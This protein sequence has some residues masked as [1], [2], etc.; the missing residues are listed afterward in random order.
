MSELRADPPD[1]R[2]E[3]AAS[4][5]LRYRL[6]T[7]ACRLMRHPVLPWIEHRPAQRRTTRCLCGYVDVG[8]LGWVDETW[9]PK[10]DWVVD[11]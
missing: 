1:G 7:V 4:S 9:R 6:V 3:K 10:P 8:Q 5:R 2:V 11:E